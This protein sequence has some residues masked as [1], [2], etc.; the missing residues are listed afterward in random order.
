M[1]ERLKPN[2]ALK[3]FYFVDFPPADEFF[4]QTFLNSLSEYQ[5]MDNIENN[6]KN[7]CLPLNKVINQEYFNYKNINWSEGICI[8]FWHTPLVPLPIHTDTDYEDNKTKLGNGLN[9]NLFNKS[10]VNFYKTYKVKPYDTRNIPLNDS[11]STQ[12]KIIIET[13]KKS[14]ASTFYSEGGP[15]ES[16]MTDHG[17]TYIINTTLP[18][19]L[20]AEQGRICLSVRCDYFRNKSWQDMVNFFQDSI[21]D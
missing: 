14:R 20:L 10:V 12:E 16:Y 3:S 4:N 11:L 8:I 2:R 13:N 9:F 5:S 6:F 18:H 21:K 19:Q 15:S 7:S 1:T 17:D